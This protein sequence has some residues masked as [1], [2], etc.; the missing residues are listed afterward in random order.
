MYLFIFFAQ[1]LENL[2]LNEC[3]RNSRKSGNEPAKR[4]N[5]PATIIYLARLALILP[6]LSFWS[7]CQF[8][9]ERKHQYRLVAE[10]FHG[11]NGQ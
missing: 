7:F 10:M 4:L 5:I 6:N 1:K 2:E 11:V 8:L 3:N 9:T